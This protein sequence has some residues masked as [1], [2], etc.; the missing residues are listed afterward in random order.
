MKMKAQTFSLIALLACIAGLSASWGQAPPSQPPAKPS[1]VQPEAPFQYHAYRADMSD[2]NIVISDTGKSPVDKAAV[3]AREE[4]EAQS[5]QAVSDGEAFLK[6]GKIQEEIASYKN[7]L[8]IDPMNKLAHQRLAEADM[9]CGKLDE[10]SQNFHKIL[11][12]GFKPGFGPGAGGNSNVW[13]NYAL[14]LLETK[15]EADALQAY[16]QGAFIADYEFDQNDPNKKIAHLS[17]MFPEIAVTP[18]SPGQVQCTPEILRALTDTLLAD[19]K[20]G[21]GSDEEAIAHMKEAAKLYPDSA[22]VQYYLGLALSYSYYVVLDSPV[23]DKTALWAG[24][25]ED[26]KAMVAAYQ[27]AAELGN[28]QTAAA[29]KEKIAVTR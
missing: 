22:V 23:K 4:R 18:T 1:V 2:P 27:K 10:A 14:V 9:A 26:K 25:E 6:V 12:E 8:V 24:Y 7:A 29:A 20:M 5:N 19:S 17:V 15:H 13:A 11:V 16:N 3:K 21:H 28:E